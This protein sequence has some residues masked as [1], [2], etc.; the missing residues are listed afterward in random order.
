MSKILI[1]KEGS[2]ISML[3]DTLRVTDDP[4]IPYIEGDGIGKDIWASS[5]RVINSAVKKAYD[6]VQ[7]P[8]TDDLQVLLKYNPKSKIKFI[9]GSYNNFKI[10]TDIDLKILKVLYHQYPDLTK[11]Y[12]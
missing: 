2:K 11:F 6:N 1:P 4:I 5:K 12:E 9:K 10:T 7:A 8:Q 3:D